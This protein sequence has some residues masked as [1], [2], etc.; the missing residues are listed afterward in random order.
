STA[1][2]ECKV[3]SDA[4][5]HWY[6][7]RP[8]EGLK[9]ILHVKGNKKTY[10]AGFTDSKYKVEYRA[11]NIY[12]LDIVKLAAEDEGTYYCAAWQL[13]SHTDTKPQ[14]A[15]TE[16]HRMSRKSTGEIRIVGTTYDTVLTVN[17]SAFH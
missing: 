16:S 6:V 8:N 5:V 4:Y 12:V 10:D 9:R 1:R 7:Q 14:E 3:D 11:D 13:P 2:I 17:I 15:C